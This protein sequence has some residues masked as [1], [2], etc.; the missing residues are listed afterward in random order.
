M[1]MAQTYYKI[2]DTS[3]LEIDGEIYLCEN[4]HMSFNDFISKHTGKEIYIHKESIGTD[5]I[6]A[7][8]IDA[9]K[10]DHDM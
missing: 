9:R 8:V 10:T 6:R 3:A 2:I 1:I 7:I 5:I 4:W